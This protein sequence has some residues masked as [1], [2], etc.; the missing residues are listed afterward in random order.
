[1]IKC[2]FKNKNYNLPYTLNYIVYLSFFYTLELN[3]LIVQTFLNNFLIRINVLHFVSFKRIKSYYYEYKIEKLAKH[4]V[5]IQNVSPPLNFS[6]PGYQSQCTSVSSISAR[7]HDTCSVRIHPAISASLGWRAAWGSGRD[8]PSSS[9]PI[10][11]ISSPGGFL[12]YPLPGISPLGRAPRNRR[13][14]PPRPIPNMHTYTYR[15]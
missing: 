12:G 1:M 6:L 8:V 7:T 15:V 2:K 11:R 5:T 4:N 13:R 9:R 3:C 10:S 14:P